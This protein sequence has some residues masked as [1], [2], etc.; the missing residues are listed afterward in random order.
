M[1]VKAQ[2][3]K[4]SRYENSGGDSRTRLDINLHGDF[5]DINV[6]TA[7]SSG[8]IGINTTNQDKLHIYN[9][10]IRLEAWSS[11]KYK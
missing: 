8:N 4:L 6:L 3:F 5:D 11:L 1:K 10:Y 2:N 7:L 9:G